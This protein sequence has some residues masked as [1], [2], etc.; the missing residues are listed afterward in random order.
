MKQD[1]FSSLAILDVD[2]NA[3]NT[4]NPLNILEMHAEEHGRLQHLK[5]N[6]TID[7]ICC[8]AAATRR[9]TNDNNNKKR[10]TRIIQIIIW[11]ALKGIE[12][13]RLLMDCIQGGAA[14]KQT[15]RK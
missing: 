13:G 3:F 4:A 9:F 1:R 2:R 7:I 6:R 15:I 5:Y 11:I 10:F 8:N 12:S 14:V